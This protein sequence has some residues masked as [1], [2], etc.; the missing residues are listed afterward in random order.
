MRIA[1]I[2]PSLFTWPY[3]AALASALAARGHQVAVFGRPFEPGEATPEAPLLRPHFYQTLDAPFWRDLPKPLFLGAKGVAH[4]AGMLR[5]LDELKRYAP[6]VIHMQWTPLPP[7]DRWFLPALRR[8]APTLLTVHD[9]SPFNSNP[10]SPVQRWGATSIFAGFDHLIVHTQEAARQL[11]ARGLPSSRVSQIA[12][13]PLGKLPEIVRRDPRR[14]EPDRLRIVLFGRLKPYKG[15]DILVRAAAA[16]PKALLRRCRI[17]I[18]GQAFMD[19]EPLYRVVDASGIGGSVEFDLRFLDEEE[20]APLL[21][22]ADIIALPYRQIDASGVLMSSL[23]AGVPVVA[24]RIGLFD[25]LLVDGE[26]GYLVPP[27]DH[28]ALAQALSA[29]VAD[30][31]LRA[32]MGANV[33]TLMQKLP[34]WDA[35]AASTE[36]LYARLQQTARDELQKA[37]AQT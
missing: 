15:A 1:M 33:R 7:V 23:A 3:D 25:E 36:K 32:R 4:V 9:S 20:V 22:S 18:V 11:Q 12:H 31:D 6:E 35:I 13:G 34:G 8:L 26:H 2:D 14:S 10:S 24:S 21:A 27:G 17:S 30:D 16:M 19:M 28:I 5:L 37:T 29:L